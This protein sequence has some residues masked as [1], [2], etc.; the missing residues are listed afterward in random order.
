[1]SG[2]NFTSIL[3]DRED[4]P[5]GNVQHI[6]KHNVTKEEV[7]DVFDRPSGTDTSRSSGR[8]MVFGDTRAGRHLV[9]IY[10]SIDASSAYPITAYDVPKRKRP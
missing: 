7:E 9:V 10:E 3:W 2:P 8:P 5:K 4:D 6:A 1:M